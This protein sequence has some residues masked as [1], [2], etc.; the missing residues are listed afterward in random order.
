MP[1]AGRLQLQGRGVRM[2][3][4]WLHVGLQ[5]Q[6]RDPESAR[7][8]QQMADVDEPRPVVVPLRNVLADQVVIGQLPVL[9]EHGDARRDHRLRIGSHAEHRVGLHVDTAPL[10]APPQRLVH[11]DLAVPGHEQHRADQIAVRDSLLVQRHT[12][13]K[14]PRGHPRFGGRRARDDLPLRG[15][16]SGRY[17]SPQCGHKRR[18][19]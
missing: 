5:E 12:A 7:M 8:R 1:E 13:G 6:R 3:R 16:V 17:R 19:C 14:N 9:H 15:H 2:F 18:K 4:A 11:H 10:V